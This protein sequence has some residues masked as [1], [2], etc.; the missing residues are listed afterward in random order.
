MALIIL[1]TYEPQ[2]TDKCNNPDPNNQG[3]KEAQS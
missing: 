2:K 1:I 3:D